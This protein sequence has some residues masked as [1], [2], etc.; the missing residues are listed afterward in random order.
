M[1]IKP[2]LAL[3]ALLGA[4]LA[5]S[6]AAS[7]AAA[8]QT[9]PPFT[10]ERF[11][12]HVT[13]LADD[14]LEGRET[15][16]RG[17]E[18]AARYVASQFAAAGL[19]PG[20]GDGSWFQ[21]ITFQKTERGETP[22]AITVIDP[23]RGAAAGERRWENATDVLVW[24]NANEPSQDISAPLVFVGY[25]VENARFGFDDYRGLDAKGKIVVV[26]RGFPKGLPSEEGAHLAA[27]KLKTAEQHGAIGVISIA[28]LQS[29]KTRSWA[30]NVAAS[31]D[32]ADY[33]WMDSTGKAHVEA[34]G[35]RASG[36]L[37]TP[38]AE[39]VF[40]GAPRT[41]AAVLREADKPGG[42]PRGFALK[43]RLRVQ[44]TSR[45]EHV[46]SPNV[47]GILRGADPALRDQYVV[48]SAHLDHLGMAP[49][50]KDKPG[51]DRIY[52]GALDN[53]AGVATMLEVARAAASAPTRPRRSIIFIATT[54]EERGLLGADYYAQNPTVPI[55]QIVGN[56]DLDMP[57]LLYPFTDLVAFGANHS[58]F[59]RLVAEAV[60][61]MGVA[62]SP[63]PMPE[64]GLFTRS[65][66]YQFVRQGVPAIFFATGYANGGQKA[67]ETFLNGGYHEPNDDVTQKID[68]DSGARFAEANYRVTRAMADADQPPLWLQGDF[69]GDTFAPGRARAPAPP[70]PPKR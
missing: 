14:L 6:L 29:A 56:V 19:A 18:I 16:S 39:A 34:P 27:T 61:P 59:G 64:Q 32:G 8:Q 13:F 9:A 57:V 26:L 69:F 42:T 12:S 40:S 53:A 33:A 35:I 67:W 1:R 65:D 48:L 10:A 41:L 3:T 5:G 52:N 36:A 66:H 17:H 22:G 63:D 44:T 37:N 28:T 60:A 25:G 2:A 21:R 45:S 38:A 51:A 20:G 55:G 46:T 58:S 7:P 47:V 49:E 23:A 50:S 24:T 11:R 62:L 43:T 54:G 70:A 30:Q 15:G 4:A 68:W 31:A